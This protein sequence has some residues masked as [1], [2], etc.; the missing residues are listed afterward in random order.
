MCYQDNSQGLAER[1]KEGL[2]EGQ[3]EV[4]GQNEGRVLLSQEL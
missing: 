3:N 4:E 2:A 1:Q